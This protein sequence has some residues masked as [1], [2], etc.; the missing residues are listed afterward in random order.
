MVR[1]D[2]ELTNAR[3]WPEANI[4]L[5]QVLCDD[6]CHRARDPGKT[7]LNSTPTAKVLFRVPDGDGGVIVETLWAIPIGEDRYQ[8]DNSPFFAYDVSWED[9]V[10]APFNDAEGMPTFES[11]VRPSGNRTI[12]IIFDLPIFSGNSSDAVI[13]GLIALGCSYEGAND[14]YISVNIPATVDLQAVCAYLIHHEAHWEHADPRYVAI[15]PDGDN[16]T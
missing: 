8:L 13:Q 9:I 1:R 5:V 4:E 3:F 6:A 14:R 15:Y 12:R 7:H 16:A 11:V 2:S 10:F